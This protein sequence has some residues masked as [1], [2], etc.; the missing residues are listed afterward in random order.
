MAHCVEGFLEVKKDSYNK[1]FFIK[2][3][4]YFSSQFSNIVHCGAAPKEPILI[5][6]QEVI[7]FKMVV[8]AGG[9]YFFQDFGDGTKQGYGSIVITTGV[10]P[11]FED[12]NGFACFKFGGEHTSGDTKGEEVAK[13]FRYLIFNGFQNLHTDAIGIST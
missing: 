5:F 8:K 9:Y 13:G 12:W 7:D 11:G 10:I 2:V 4:G 1:F 6:I 3:L